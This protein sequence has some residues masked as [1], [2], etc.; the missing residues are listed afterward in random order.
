MNG[1]IL[2]T[3]Y[4][5]WVMKEPE[6]IN[7]DTLRLIRN[8]QNNLLISL[9]SLWEIAIKQKIGKLNMIDS[10]DNFKKDVIDCG[11][12]WLRIE[13]KHIYTTLEIPLL[14]EHRD[15][16]D[17]LLIAQAKTEGLII[18]TDD[19]KFS[20]YNDINVLN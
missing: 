17:R 15:P 11:F 1:Y 9:V 10:I 2:D 6:K 19:S 12:N 18:I 5:I 7:Q 14:Q 16:F 20:L 4:L 13:D 8:T 3:H